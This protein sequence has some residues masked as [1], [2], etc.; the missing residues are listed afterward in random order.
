[1]KRSISFIGTLSIVIFQ[2]FSC[3]DE[4]IATNCQI[5]Q[6]FYSY[7]GGGWD[8]TEVVYDILDRITGINHANIL[9]GDNM[10]TV[11]PSDLSTSSYYR[12]CKNEEG[13][14][15]SYTFFSCCGPFGEMSYDSLL[16]T[17]DGNKIISAKKF[18]NKNDFAPSYIVKYYYDTMGNVLV[19]SQ[20]IY[21]S[22]EFYGITTRE[23]NYALPAQ[24]DFI[25]YQNL[26]SIPIVNL[27]FPTQNF[28]KSIAILFPDAA[29]DF[30]QNWSFTYEFG[31][32][33]KVILYTRDLETQHPDYTSSNS[34]TFIF[35]WGCY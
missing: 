15:I 12:Y 17:Y 19:D 24:N 34:A 5:N 16:Y 22:E 13:Q 30:I 8:T 11:F 32:N 33:D 21:G 9:Y 25:D 4:E 18:L 28:I 31:E 10:I 35:K 23:Y 26:L 6:I 7:S 3:K 29:G 2:L 20:F 1:M 14:I 27:A